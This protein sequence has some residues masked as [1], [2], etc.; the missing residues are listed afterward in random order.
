MMGYQCNPLRIY[1][2]VIL[3]IVKNGVRIH[4][5]HTNDLCLTLFSYFAVYITARDYSKSTRTIIYISRC[6]GLTI[7]KLNSGSQMFTEKK[8]DIK[9]CERQT[10]PQLTNFTMS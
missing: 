8:R 2:V 5:T 4:S 6:A 1:F 10:L 9:F 7:Y 3:Q